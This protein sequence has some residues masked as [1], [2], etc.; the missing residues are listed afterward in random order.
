MSLYLFRRVVF[1][2]MET[3]AET[4]RELL[5]AAL[6]QKKYT[7]AAI[8]IDACEQDVCGIVHDLKKALPDH[9]IFVE[10]IRGEDDVEKIVRRNQRSL[11]DVV[12][13]VSSCEYSERIYELRCNAHGGVIALDFGVL[14]EDLILKDFVT[15]VCA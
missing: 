7:L 6:K 12:I 8:V 1:L 4:G 14:T 10:E 5:L 2:P 9:D 11:S 13:I 15:Q 3:I